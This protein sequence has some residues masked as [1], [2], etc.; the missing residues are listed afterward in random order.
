[1][2]GSLYWISDSLPGLIWF[3]L[4]YGV[5]GIPAALVALPRMQWRDRAAV[6]ALAIAFAPALLT[7][8]LFILGS[9]GAALNL[10]LMTPVPML[11]GCSVMAVGLWGMVWQKYHIEHSSINERA[12]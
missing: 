7:A 1:M 12:T 9:L 4:V 10:P 8:W 2:N 11:I 3:A 6:G 5:L